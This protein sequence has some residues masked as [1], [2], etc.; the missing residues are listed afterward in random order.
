ME[1]GAS[2]VVVSVAVVT[3]SSLVDCGVLGSGF[4]AA[5]AAESRVTLFRD[6]QLAFADA[7]GPSFA[8][9]PLCFLS[10]IIIY[11]KGFYELS[12]NVSFIVEYL[13]F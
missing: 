8:F 1:A 5:S 13:K 12:V 4:C 7:V 11:E 2:C 6:L 3:L 9:R 10:F